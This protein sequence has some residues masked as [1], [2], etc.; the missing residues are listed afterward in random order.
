[1]N[2]QKIKVILPGAVVS[3]EDVKSE[4]EAI[5]QVLLAGQVPERKT[6]D[7]LQRVFQEYFQEHRKKQEASQTVEKEL[8]SKEDI[9]WKDVLPQKG[10]EL[11]VEENLLSEPD[12]Y[13]FLQKL[14]MAKLFPVP[15]NG[16]TSFIGYLE[17]LGLLTSVDLEGNT[18]YLLTT[19]GWKWIA[20]ESVKKVLGEIN[21]SFVF[22]RK[23]IPDLS[24]WTASTFYQLKL[25]KKYYER[26]GISDFMIFTDD[27]NQKI[28]FGCEIKD[29]Y[30]VN[31]CCAVDNEGNIS[32]EEASRIYELGRDD[33]IDEII[34]IV[35]TEDEENRLK[36]QK[37]L[38][39][40]NLTKLQFYILQE[41]GNN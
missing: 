11:L 17:N 33:K 36:L 27:K 41:E 9:H 10:E 12:N 39:S 24:V 5:L 37:G 19:K 34:L 13:R 15:T 3:T 2:N 6:N 30:A 29:S 38:D 1:M 28:Q 25:I 16:D 32:Q 20:D 35:H 7:N 26:N 23:L 4:L 14:I 21:F 31:Y 22:P 18:T 8:K 40:R